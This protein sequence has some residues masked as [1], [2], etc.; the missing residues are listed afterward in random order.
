MPEYHQILD[1]GEKSCGELIVAI[2]RALDEL[3]G[4]EVLKLLTE[5]PGAKQDLPAFCRMTGHRL[6]WG[7]GPTYYIQRREG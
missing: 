3:R 4:G 2:K 6:L 7:E 1:G 5:D